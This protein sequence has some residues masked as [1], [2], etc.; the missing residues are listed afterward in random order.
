MHI[1]ICVFIHI[2]IYTYIQSKKLGILSI[3][4]NK[5]E[6]FNLNFFIVV[7][8]KDSCWVIKVNWQ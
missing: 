8:I 3:N 4:N 5:A 6:F 7:I 2:Y 1:H